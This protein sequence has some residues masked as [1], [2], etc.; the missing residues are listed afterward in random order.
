M[1]ALS[2]DTD[3]HIDD[4][5]RFVPDPTT[6]ACISRRIRKTIITAACKKTM[7]AARA[8]ATRTVRKLEIVCLP[9]PRPIFC[10]GARLPA[11]YAN[12]YIANDVCSCRCSTMPTTNWNWEY[13]RRFSQAQNIALRCKKWGGLGAIHCVTQQEPAVR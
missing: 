8:R 11:S 13:C 1:K 10:D 4:I 12:F 6:V 2:R 3:G 5:A 9:C 7:S